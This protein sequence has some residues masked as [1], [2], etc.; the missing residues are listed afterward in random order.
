MKK[1]KEVITGI[2]EPGDS[3]GE[4]SLTTNEPLEY[5]II[6]ETYLVMA[7]VSIDDIEGKF[8]FVFMNYANMLSPIAPFFLL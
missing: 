5:S 7:T 6:S 2:L 1:S 3:F 4:K 8:K